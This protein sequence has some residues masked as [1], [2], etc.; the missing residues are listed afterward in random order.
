MVGG[1]RVPSI[2]EQ[3]PRSSSLDGLGEGGWK[4]EPVCLRDNFESL[5]FSLWKTKPAVTQDCPLQ[6]PAPLVTMKRD[7]P[8]S[9][10]DPSPLQT[11]HLYMYDVLLVLWL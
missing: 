2:L 10:V 9:W 4:D 3:H 5:H 7:Y 6:V 1:T 11:L 8:A